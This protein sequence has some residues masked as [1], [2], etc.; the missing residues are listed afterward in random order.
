[1]PL[2][3]PKEVGKGFGGIKLFKGKKKVSPTWKTTGRKCMNSKTSQQ[4]RSCG[5]PPS[6]ILHERASEQ[7]KPIRRRFELLG[8]N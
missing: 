4:H 8:N 5:I 6:S 1:M 3:G 2:L 7:Q